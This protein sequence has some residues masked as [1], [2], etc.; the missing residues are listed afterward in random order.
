MRQVLTNLV[1]NAVKFTADGHV[2][3]RVTGVPDEAGETCAV[4]I[5]VEDTGIGI[6]PDKIDAILRPFEQADLS[7]TRRYG[8]TGLGLSICVQLVELMGGR[9]EIESESGSG[10]TFRFSI[11]LAPGTPRTER[12]RVAGRDEIE[13]LNVLIVDDN[14]TNRRIL[15]RDAQELEDA[16]G[17]GGRRSGRAGRDRPGG[18]RR[19]RL[20]SRDL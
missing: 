17:I 15:V 19:E 9:I 16:R 18:E 6:P 2:V 14:D 5:S 10:S 3:I 20:R 1:G 7:T 11:V 13:D 12:E 4:H 8:G